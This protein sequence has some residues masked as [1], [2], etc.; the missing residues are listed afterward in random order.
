MGFETHGDNSVRKGERSIM[1]VKVTV[2]LNSSNINALV[3]A[4]Q[5]AHKQ[6]TMLIKDDIINSQVVPKLTGALEESCEVDISEVSAG[7]TSINFDRPY[8]ARLYFHPEFNFHQDKN[9]NAQG[10]WMQDYIDGGKDG[11]AKENLS[12]LFKELSKGVIK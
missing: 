9:K 7:H 12:K 4:A 11:F 3:A 1:N 8:A 6:T 10:M 5:E 2:K